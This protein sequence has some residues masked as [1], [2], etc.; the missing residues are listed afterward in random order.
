MTDDPIIHRSDEPTTRPKR[1]VTPAMVVLLLVIVVLGGFLVASVTRLPFAIGSDAARRS[2]SSDSVGE[3]RA[4]I[5][6]GRP[7][8]VLFHSLT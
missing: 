3:Y 6:D 7:V 2:S 5:E 4:A 1:P 8:Y